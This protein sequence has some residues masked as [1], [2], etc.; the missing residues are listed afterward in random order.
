M[1]QQLTRDGLPLRVLIVEDDVFTAMDLEDIITASG[2][3]VVG[4]AL[5]ARTGLEKLFQHTPDIALLDVQLF[6]QCDGIKLASVIR[7]F[8][9]AEIVFCTGHRDLRTLTRI[10]D[11]QANVLL[12]PFTPEQLNAA[13]LKAADKRLPPRIDC[14]L[15]WS[16]Q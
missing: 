11:L 8:H 9:G 12:K 6:G 2:G 4:I 7:E 14:G 5:E 3:Q 13:L 16:R 10:A 1:H 15:D